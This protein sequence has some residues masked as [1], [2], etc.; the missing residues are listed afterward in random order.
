MSHC[1]VDAR[2]EAEAARRALLDH[3]AVFGASLFSPRE[4]PRDAWTIELALRPSEDGLPPEVLY[5]VAQRGLT[6]VRVQQRS[7]TETL[8]LLEL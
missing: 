2:D 3:T 1:I 6:V 7:P 5:T 8:A 4:D